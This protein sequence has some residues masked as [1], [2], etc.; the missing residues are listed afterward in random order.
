MGIWTYL[1]PI[2]ERVAKLLHESKEDLPD[3]QLRRFTHA[4]AER[5]HFVT[6]GAKKSKPEAAEEKESGEEDFALLEQAVTA[7][8]DPS[9]SPGS[10]STYLECTKGKSRKYFKVELAHTIVE[11]E[12]GR[13]GTQ[14]SA[15]LK[16]FDSPEEAKAFYDKKIKEKTAKSKGYRKVNLGAKI[17]KPYK[18]LW[19]QISEEPHPNKR[20]KLKEG[21]ESGGE[22]E[23]GEGTSGGA[24]GIG[25][26]DLD[27]AGEAVTYAICKAASILC[28][29]DDI[30]LLNYLFP[31][32]I[33]YG[34]DVHYGPI[35]V[36][37]AAEV[38]ALWETLQPLTAEQVIDEGLIPN[39]DPDWPLTLGRFAFDKTL[40]SLPADDLEYF[41]LHLRALKKF[42]EMCAGNNDIG[43][44]VRYS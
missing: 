5:S 9:S 27:K 15:D 6:D 8:A 42:V 25:F 33:T 37:R 40:A 23:K 19:S 20:Q 2:D 41:K 28:E 17:F 38:K 18:T 10:A 14:N 24:S 21:T 13:I 12:Y 1:H 7:A 32:S 34:K 26:L 35:R 22:E 11:C 4:L 31:H 39:K 3:A 44:V 43:L 16:R 29:G 30:H 36:V